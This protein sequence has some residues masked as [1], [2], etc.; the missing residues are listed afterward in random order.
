M[1]IYFAYLADAEVR[2]TELS[3]CP[4]IQYKRYSGYMKHYTTTC[5]LKNAG[6]EYVLC[7]VLSVS[8]Y[9]WLFF[10]HSYVSREV[11][12]LLVLTRAMGKI[13]SWSLWRWLFGKRVWIRTLRRLLS[14]CIASFLKQKF[15]L[16]AEFTESCTLACVFESDGE[17]TDA[18]TPQH[19]QEAAALIPTTLCLT[20]SKF[21]PFVYLWY[22]LYTHFNKQLICHNEDLFWI[23]SGH[24]SQTCIFGQM[25]V[26]QC[27]IQTCP[28]VLKLF[29]W[30]LLDEANISN[31]L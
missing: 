31:T 10:I 7:W 16:H 30:C 28:K 2:C 12:W 8:R 1:Q 29:F 4:S 9:F 11:G 27:I 15:R 17:L 22:L 5:F 21:S 20:W 24:K 6:F 18:I 3:Q 19:C 25:W 14:D 23:R 13:K 26:L